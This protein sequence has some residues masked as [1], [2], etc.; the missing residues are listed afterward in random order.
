MCL[1]KADT[2]YTFLY[3]KSALRD[4]HVTTCVQKPDLL[5]LAFSLCVQPRKGLFYRLLLV[6]QLIP[7]ELQPRHMPRLQDLRHGA[8]EPIE[9]ADTPSPRSI[10]AKL[11]K[12]IPCKSAL[13]ARY[14]HCVSR[15]WWNMRGTVPAH[16]EL[17]SSI[18]AARKCL[19]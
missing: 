17:L 6:R 10:T 8:P 14:W 5:A 9:P 12:T 2:S 1:A 19:P 7:P 15:L 11:T 4:V 16:Q 13:T 18:H 3:Q